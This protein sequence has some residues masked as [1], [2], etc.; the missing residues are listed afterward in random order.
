MWL[1]STVLCVTVPA[2]LRLPSS[3]TLSSVSYSAEVLARDHDS[4]FQSSLIPLYDN[5]PQGVIAFNGSLLL[6]AR[7]E[8][9]CVFVENMQ[10]V[11][12]RLRVCVYMVRLLWEWSNWLTVSSAVYLDTLKS[13]HCSQC[14]NAA[15]CYWS[16]WPPGNGAHP[17][18]LPS[19]LSANRLTKFKEQF[20]YHVVRFL[21]MSVANNVVHIPE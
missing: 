19:I 16:L 7:R 3:S 1:R 17:Y 6:P 11:Q 12:P 10:S 2:W 4:T 9:V 20:D 13:S 18:C 8:K 15:P 21:N 14:S 5:S